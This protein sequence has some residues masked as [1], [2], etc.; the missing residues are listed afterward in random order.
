MTV[1]GHLDSSCRAFYN[2]K[3]FLHFYTVI[4]SN[5]LADLEKLQLSNCHCIT[6][7]FTSGIKR[8]SSPSIS[9]W[10]L[11]ALVWMYFRAI[12]CQ[13]FVA[14]FCSGFQ[15]CS[16]NPNATIFQTYLHSVCHA[17]FS[18][19]SGNGNRCVTYTHMC[20]VH[21]NQPN[22]YKLIHCIYHIFLC[23]QICTFL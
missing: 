6:C 14:V 9:A 15:P 21:K 1:K 23:S 11:P 10:L 7:T 5:K 20:P 8:A 16:R 18:G 12:F 17:V 13:C 3:H 4:F 2:V 22:P 19:R